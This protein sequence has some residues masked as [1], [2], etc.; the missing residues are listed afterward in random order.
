MKKK[1][2]YSKKGQNH[3]GSYYWTIYYK[4]IALIEIGTF[5]CRTLLLKHLNKE[6]KK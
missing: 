4:R 6:L 3:N 2:Y 5:E 1:K